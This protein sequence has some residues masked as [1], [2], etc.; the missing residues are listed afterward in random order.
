MSELPAPG[1][2]FQPPTIPESPGPQPDL[3]PIPVELPPQ[4]TLPDPPPLQAWPIIQLFVPQQSETR[5]CLQD[6]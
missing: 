5:G 2:P 1:P 3:P 6:R 4:P